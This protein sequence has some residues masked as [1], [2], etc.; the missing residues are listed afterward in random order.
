MRKTLIGILLCIVMIIAI[1]IGTV[2]AED[3]TTEGHEIVIT[4]EDNA[5][6]VEES[7]TIQGESNETYTTISFW[8]QSG[9]EDLTIL[10]NTN[11]ITP[12]STDNEYVCD[13]SSLNIVQ[14]ASMQVT[15]SYNLG[16]NIE[17]FE[18]TI[19]RNTDSI[20]VEF[21][22]NEIYTGEDLNAN[23]YFKIELYKPTETPLSGYVIVIILLLVIL[24]VVLTIYSFRKQKT[25]TIDV[26]SESEEL[27][28]TQ[29]TLLMTILKDIEK[30]HRSKQISDDTYHKL[31]E[32]YKQQ[33]VEAMK[34]I[35]DAES[36]VK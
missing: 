34:K 7:L 15:I 11:P 31:K 4:T 22:G 27:L 8:V 16:K 29:K 5:I 26:G 21:D 13:I 30:Q 3:V 9:A 23:V 19:L 33:A 32:Q 1:P 14:N 35:E 12:T 20:T 2:C 10:V 17:K 6:A 18:K 24:V 25:K 28:T 36:K